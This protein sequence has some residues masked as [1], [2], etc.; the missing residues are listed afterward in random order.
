MKSGNDTKQRTTMNN[1]KKVLTS[2]CKFL[3]LVLRH[4]PKLVGM[5][6]DPE[7]WLIESH[8]VQSVT[9]LD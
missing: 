4:Q 5:Q 8:S 1:P 2:T 6:L 3:S 9:T 7:G